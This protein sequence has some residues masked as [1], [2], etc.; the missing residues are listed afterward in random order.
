[1]VT[2][3]QAR[4]E[5]VPALRE[6]AMAAY[7]RY[8]PRLGGQLPAPVTADYAAAVASGNTWVAELEGTLVGLM[9]VWPQPDHALLE[10]VAVHPE[11]HGLGI[12]RQLM[13]MA[14]DQARDW[15]TSEIRLYTNVV[16]TENL[17]L[18]PRLG[19]R[20]THRAVEDGFERV[21]MAKRLI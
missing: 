17:A 21:F 19:Y 10:N 14:E 6:L 20:E 4:G 3:R 5:D 11:R 8:L 12:G 2:I 13:R 7:A 18:Y 1:M 9:I 16:M 15:G